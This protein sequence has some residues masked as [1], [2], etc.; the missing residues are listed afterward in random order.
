MELLLGCGVSRERK[1][2]FPGRDQWSELITLD[3]YHECKPDVVHDLNVLPYPFADNTFDEIHAYEVLEHQGRQGDWKFF[4][5][6][7]A[8]L[9]RI[10]KPGG[11]LC[12][13]CP[14]YS[15]PWAWGDPSHTR[16]IGLEQL[17]FLSQQVYRDSVGVS[18]MT[19][20]RWYYKADWVLHS[21]EALEHILAF[22]LRAQK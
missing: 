2:T 8:E 1:I 17:S 6:Q 21:H 10:T 18:P 15:S 12:A 22:A 11:L 9:W 20:F 3:M 14:L 16:I 5:D 19:D 4:F 13:T 7:F